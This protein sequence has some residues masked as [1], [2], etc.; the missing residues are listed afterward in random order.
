M[1]FRKS[2][3]KTSLELTFSTTFNFFKPTSQIFGVLEALGPTASTLFIHWRTQKIVMRRALVSLI[4]NAGVTIILGQ[5]F[6]IGGKFDPSWG[7]C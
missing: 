2:G 7:P 1:L 4:K 3:Q 6:S 5:G